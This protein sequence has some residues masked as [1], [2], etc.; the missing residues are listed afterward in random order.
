MDSSC[1]QYCNSSHL[2]LHNDKST[3]VAK[4]VWFK[5]D[6]I[7][8]NICNNA[9]NLLY[10]TRQWVL[11]QKDTETPLFLLQSNIQVL[12]VV[13]K[14]HTHIIVGMDASLNKRTSP[15]KNHTL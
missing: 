2:C 11:I 7:E 5:C 3:K 12:H 13:S 8:I 9:L 6:N 10:R 14:N 1:Q 15:T 4:Y